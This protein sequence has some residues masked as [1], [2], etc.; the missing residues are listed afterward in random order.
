M[1]ACRVTVFGTGHWALTLADLARRS[2]SR[3][4][5]YAR[6]REIAEVLRADRR[7]PTFLPHLVLDPAIAVT[8]NL[9]EAA[10]FSPY[11]V[12][13]VPSAY[14]RDLCEKIGPRARDDVQV[15]SAAKGI[16]VGTFFRMSEV[17]ADVMAK[18]HRHPGIGVLSG[19]NLAADISRGLPAASTVAVDATVF[20][21]WVDILGRANLRLYHQTDR[22]GVELGGALKNILAIAVG[23]ADQAGLGDSA[24]AA[25]MTRGLHEMGRLAVRL[26]ANWMTLAGLSGLGDLVAT[27]SSPLSRNRWCG[28]EL[29]KGRP[30]RD[31]LASTSMVVEGVPT[32]RA[33]YALGR[34]LHLPLPITNEVVAIFDGKT[35][36]EALADLMTRALVSET[37][38]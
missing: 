35:V 14:V 10:E 32:A 4:M 13:A 36:S 19:P 21:E 7:H 17:I 15:L 31:I 30:L 18:H 1:N 2:G 5:L 11:W 22:I 28:Q 38:L 37:Q 20:A 3:V 27:S 24:K 29:A 16:E 33:V 9:D 6:R 8:D 25:L 12:L 34:Q 26:G 23:L